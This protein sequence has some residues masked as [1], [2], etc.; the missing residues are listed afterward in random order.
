MGLIRRRAGRW[1]TGNENG[2]GTRARFSWLPLVRSGGRSFC[3]CRELAVNPLIAL[4]YLMPL[5]RPLD[6]TSRATAL[7]E[8]SS[9]GFQ[10]PI[11]ECT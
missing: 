7:L 10:A 6:S 1:K 9:N 5:M 3:F 8:P 4:N 11:L 2:F